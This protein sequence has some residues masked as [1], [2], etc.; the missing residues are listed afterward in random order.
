[1][2]SPAPNKATRVLNLARRHFFSGAALLILPAVL[3]LVVVASKFD[4]IH[5]SIALDHAQVA[6][7]VA[8]GEGLTTSVI[9]PLSLAFK[10][11]LRHHPDLFNAPLHILVV[12]GFFKVFGP[13]ARVAVGSGAVLWILAVWMTFLVG[14]HWFGWRAGLLAAFLLGCNVSGV[15]AAVGALPHP[16]YSI[17]TLLCVWIG[18]R[19]T[20]KRGVGPAREGADNLSAAP[21]VEQSE[22]AIQPVSSRWGIIAAGAVCALAILSHFP[23][24]SVA[25][26]IGWCI[27]LMQPRKWKALGLFSAGFFVALAP[28]LIRVW[29]ATGSP[30]INLY[31]FEALTGTGQYPGD[32][33]WR[34]AFP[35]DQPALFVFHHPVQAGLKLL[36]GLQSYRSDA[37]DVVDPI[38]LLPF[39]VAMFDRSF[40]AQWRWALRVGAAGLIVTAL[41]ASL[42]RPE[43]PLLMAWTPLICIV[44]AGWL[45]EWLPS[46]V[47]RM[48]DLVSRNA[49][50]QERPYA[51]AWAEWWVQAAAYGVILILAAMPLMQYVF[52]ARPSGEARMPEEFALLEKKTA[53]AASVLT[54]QP[55]LI[56]WHTNRL[57]VWL[58]QREQDL[59]TLEQT[60]G[61]FDASLVT[62]AVAQLPVIQQG[63]WWY[64]VTVPKGVFHGLSPVDPSPQRP[65]LRVRTDIATR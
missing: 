26:V 39:L 10:A 15:A 6:R 30:F 43:A 53:A 5:E 42:L 54:D 17:V 29:T 21:D 16:L 3:M 31:S 56:A 7:H 50:V 55:G 2:I 24:G 48:G 61:P 44:S 35:P 58:P 36:T 65:I 60:F 52:V 33:I 11:D 25:I 41:V 1:M 4:G 32:S 47:R 45:F 37:V 22:L 28:W 8:R 62:P 46:Y 40:S 27:V 57:A 12:A 9:R 49:R 14:W 63:D 59:A 23:L 19:L 64:W 34:Y 51:R 20:G 38:V 18:L 13:T